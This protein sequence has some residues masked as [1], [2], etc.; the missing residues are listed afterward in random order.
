MLLAWAFHSLKLETVFSYNST[1]GLTFIL[2]PQPASSDRGLELTATSRLWSLPAADVR[3]LWMGTLPK[4][5]I[6]SYH[7]DAGFQ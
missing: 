7:C 4:L 2:A 5:R 1:E 6:A 3:W